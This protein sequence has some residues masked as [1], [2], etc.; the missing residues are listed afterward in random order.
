[1]QLA[2]SERSACAT[3]LEDLLLRHALPDAVVITH[4]CVEA[5]THYT[6][7]LHGRT[8]YGLEWVLLLNVPSSN[9]LAHVLRVERVAARLEVEAPEEGGWIHKEVKIRPQRFDRLYLAEL[10]VDPAETT[11]KL[12]A[13]P[14]GTGAGFDLT[15]KPDEPH[16]ELVRVLEGGAAPDAPYSVVGDDVHKL[17]S[18]HDDLV[19]MANDLAEH[20][21][22]LIEASLDETPLLE[23]E[24]PRE[25]VERLIANIA[26]TVQQIAKR[27]L[28]PGELVLKRLLG[29]NVR[30]ELFVSKAEL[31]QKLE[32]LPTSLKRVFDQLA[33][34]EPHG[35]AAET[36][37]PG[38]GS[39]AAKSTGTSTSAPPRRADA[40]AQVT[41]QPVQ[42]VSSPP[43][44]DEQP[45]FTSAPEP[46]RAPSTTTTQGSSARPP[47]P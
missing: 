32:P 10:T 26:P 4:V 31:R 2:T 34:W 39:T 21:K 36:A 45:A 43:P 35:P 23:L 11:I 8:P 7:Q 5:G 3:A 1:M 38:A 40:D 13:A 24:S 29:D 18:L 16:V 37:Q 42:L 25:L 14:E 20:R 19:A 9:P 30:E 15:F 44:P 22:S 28:T 12:R 47:R 27:S 46:P 41:P 6:A 17:R 33:L